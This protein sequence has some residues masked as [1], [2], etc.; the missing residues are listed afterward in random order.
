MIV[1]SEDLKKGVAAIVIKF[2]LDNDANPSLLKNLYR[3]I[4]TLLECGQSMDDLIR[5]VDDFMADFMQSGTGNG[6][7]H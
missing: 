4:M 3:M 1:I 7:K 2:A 6:K 5:N